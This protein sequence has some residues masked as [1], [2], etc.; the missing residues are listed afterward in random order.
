MNERKDPLL[1]V[2]LAL[3]GTSVVGVLMLAAFVAGVLI[4]GGLGKVY[5]PGIPP[6]KK[7]MY[8]RDLKQAG[9]SK[10]ATIVVIQGK[11]GAQFD[12]PGFKLPAGN[13]VTW[14]NQTEQTQVLVTDSGSKDITLDPGQSVDMPFPQGGRHYTWHL[15]S[16]PNASITVYVAG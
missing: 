7:M 5:P 2:A 14:R 9:W 1:Y 6:F 12:P 3:L 4:G 15:A 10:T 8:A 13:S 11:S 16:N